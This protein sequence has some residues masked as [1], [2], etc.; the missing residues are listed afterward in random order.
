MYT[1]GKILR[2]TGQET[3]LPFPILSTSTLLLVLICL[4]PSLLT[5][6]PVKPSLALD[7]SPWNS[8]RFSAS[9]ICM[10]CAKESAWSRVAIIPNPSTRA[11][12]TPPTVALPIIEAS[13]VLAARTPPV[14]A[15]LNMEFQGS[16]LARQRINVHSIAEN[17]PP[18]MAK[19]PAT[20]GT[21]FFAAVTPP[22]SLL[23]RPDGAFRKPVAL[24]EEGDHRVNDPITVHWFYLLAKSETF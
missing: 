24:C 13:P 11:K 14:R 23:W 21:L 16:S 22:I 10:W 8:G 2:K 6:A 4:G 20:C 7:D 5:G 12:K 19:F 18:H 3:H 9:Y 1:E 15:P 17:S